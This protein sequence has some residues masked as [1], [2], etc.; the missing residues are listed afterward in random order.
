MKR[1]KRKN[2][3]QETRRRIT[4]KFSYYNNNYL[5]ESKAKLISVQSGAVTQ[6]NQLDVPSWNFYKRPWSYQTRSSN[7]K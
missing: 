6:R 4:R 1:G 2:M 5:A 7:V 3:K